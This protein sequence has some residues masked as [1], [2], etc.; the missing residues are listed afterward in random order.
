[1]LDDKKT[2]LKTLNLVYDQ[3]TIDYVLYKEELSCYLDSDIAFHETINVRYNSLLPNKLQITKVVDPSNKE[4]PSLLRLSSCPHCYKKD[5]F[6][7]KFNNKREL[8]SEGN[9]YSKID[10]EYYCPNCNLEF[11]NRGSYQ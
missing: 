9:E 1:M 11:Q 3:K 10:M 6:L 5:L 4:I 2:R 8:N 7:S